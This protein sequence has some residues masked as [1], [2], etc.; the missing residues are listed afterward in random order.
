MRSKLTRRWRLRTGGSRKRA[1]EAGRS[2]ISRFSPRR[3]SRKTR[4]HADKAADSCSILFRRESSRCPFP[5]HHFGHPQ[6]MSR[7][8]TDTSLFM[9]TSCS[10]APRGS[11]DQTGTSTDPGLSSH[12]RLPKKP[13][14]WTAPDHGTFAQRGQ[15]HLTISLC[16]PACD[17]KAHIPFIC[18]CLS[19]GPVAELH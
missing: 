16:T 7:A 1:R 11:P 15:T 13:F 17:A 6:R 14:A 19:S 3:G 12:R 18:Q 5:R 2:R 4:S 9:L 8:P 10:A